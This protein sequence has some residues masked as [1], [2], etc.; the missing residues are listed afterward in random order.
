MIPKTLSLWFCAI[1]L[2]TLIGAPVLAAD[3][4]VA[5]VARYEVPGYHCKWS[6]DGKQIGF[7]S[8][9]TGEPKIFVMPTEGGDAVLVESGLS[10]DHWFTWTPDSRS[11]VF[12]AYGPDGPPP[13]IWLIPVKG[14]T[15]QRLV[16]D[17][18]PC[19]HPSISPDGEWLVFVSLR[20]GTS[21]IWK[22]KL[23]GDSLTQVTSNAGSNHHPQWSPDGTAILFASDRGGNWD[24]WIANADGSQTRQLTDAA[25][26]DDQPAASP[27]GKLVAFMSERSGKRDIWLVPIGDGPAQR[28]TEEGRNSWPS[29]SPDGEHLLWSANREGRTSL[30]IGKVSRDAATD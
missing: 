20:S 14:G 7:T 16:P 13:R 22:A 29:F 17:I 6:P 11:L 23:N 10:G 5:Q 8:K 9:E 26:L 3:V 2:M 18:V 4:T 1:P 30:C 27:D 12:D 28:I 24:I 25:A 19:F 21:D 15:A